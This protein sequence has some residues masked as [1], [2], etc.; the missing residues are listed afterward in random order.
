MNRKAITRGTILSTIPF[1]TLWTCVASADQ[2][3]DCNRIKNTPEKIAACTA[4]INDAWSTTQQ[5]AVAFRNR[6]LA[7][8]QAAANEHAAQ[9][10]TE[11]LK[12]DPSD[13]AAL[14]GRALIH[15]TRRNTAAAITD[16]NAAIKLKPK[17]R[18]YLMSRGYAYLVEGNSAAAIADFSEVIRLNPKHASAFNH[19][20]VAHR[21]AGDNAR[22]IADYSTAIRLNP[23]YALAYN[24]RGYVYES[25]GQ[26]SEA[27]ADFRHAL[28]LDRS[29]TGA[30]DGLK[31]LGATGALAT[32]TAAYIKEGKSLVEAK[33]SRC[34][35]V[36]LTDNSPNPRA[37]SFRKLFERHPGLALRIPLSRGIA[38]PHEDMPSFKFTN[39]QVDRIIAYINSFPETK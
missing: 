36:G 30:A 35:A 2:I 6:G 14:A 12:R 15:V 1:L 19:R 7:R 17:N 20:G 28:A 13:A 27:I 29:L 34:H 8:A 21:K 25:N 26:K 37:P 10:F 33:C 5:K 16:F 22:A 18:K 11:A 38:A 24:N 39:Q 31:R 4:I 23:A 9:D 32:E 3:A